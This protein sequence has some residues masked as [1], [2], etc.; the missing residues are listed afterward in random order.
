MN[1]RF[2]LNN[3]ALKSWWLV[4]RAYIGGIGGEHRYARSLTQ[5]EFDLLKSCD[6]KTDIPPRK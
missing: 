2:V 5:D 1:E 3:I 4:P 6:G